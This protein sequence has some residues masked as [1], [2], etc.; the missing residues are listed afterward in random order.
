MVI[1]TF[2]WHL[3]VCQSA[4]VH[5]ERGYQLHRLTPEATFERYWPFWIAGL[6]LQDEFQASARHAE[7]GIALGVRVD[8]G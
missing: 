1:P 5:G 6:Y 7:R 4:R 3:L 8:A 2:A